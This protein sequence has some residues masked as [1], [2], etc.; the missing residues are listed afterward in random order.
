MSVHAAMSFSRSRFQNSS[1]SV[2]EGSENARHAGVQTPA[3]QRT[4]VTAAG[5]APRQNADVIA[6]DAIEGRAEMPGWQNAFVLGP[7]VRFTRTP[8]SVFNRR[9]P[10]ETP[11][12]PDEEA[13]AASVPAAAEPETAVRQDAPA[14]HR[15]GRFQIAQIVSDHHRVLGPD[16]ESGQRLQKHSGAG[17]ASRARALGCVRRDQDQVEPRAGG[18]GQRRLEPPMDRRQPCLVENAAPQA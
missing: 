11:N 5:A 2:G 17:L 4:I 18:L 7:N 9:M 1:N 13:P 8:E 14:P 15:R 3:G 10:V 12:I 16:L 6:A